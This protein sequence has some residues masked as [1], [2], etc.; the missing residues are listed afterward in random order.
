MI[1]RHLKQLDIDCTVVAP[2]LI[3]KQPGD[4]I[5]TDRRDA[6]KLARLMR[7]GLKESDLEQHTLMLIVEAGLLFLIPE[8]TSWKQSETQCQVH[9]GWDHK[10]N[11]CKNYQLHN[12]LRRNSNCHLGCDARS[13]FYH[14]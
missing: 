12:Y 7:A 6:E 10:Q 9:E 8:F 3:P 14:L 1:A 13:F 5:T 4:K 11:D 2:S